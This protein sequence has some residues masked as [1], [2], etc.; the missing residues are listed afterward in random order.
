MNRCVTAVAIL[1]V[2]LGAASGAYAQARCTRADLQS[3]VNDYL[4]AQAKG[5]T[6][7]LRLATPMKYIEQ[8]QDAP[9]GKGIVNTALKVDFHRSLLDVDACETFTEVIVTDSAH[10]YVLGV[11]QKLSGGAIAE[12]EAIVTDKDDWLFNADN[13]L[14]YSRS[15]DWSP[16]AT[17][18]RDTRATLL[19]AANAYEDVFADNKV[20]VPWGTPCNRLEG[21]IRTGKGTPEDSC[22]VGVPSGMNIT[23]R[24]FVVDPE[25]GAVVALSWFSNNELPDS[26]LFRVEKGKIRFVH[27]LTVCTIPDCGFRV[28]A[29]K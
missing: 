3:A 7:G 20:V 18:A 14:K 5:T 28:P 26:H 22:N 13:Y 15:E 11:R 10:P 23:K 6:S 24:R 12:L 9:I 4:A 19:A 21:G 25:I 2:S 1:C 17:A 29:R 16:I 8:M 27:S